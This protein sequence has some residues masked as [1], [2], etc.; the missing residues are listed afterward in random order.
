MNIFKD[1]TEGLEESFSSV[2]IG[3]AG[4][5]GIGSNAAM[6]L[7]RAGVRSIV[8]VDFDKVEIQNLNRQFF[9]A[10]QVGLLKVEAL[11]R[12][13]Q[14]INKD[15]SIEISSSRL[16]IDNA[17]DAFRDCDILVEAVDDSET[18]SFLIEEWSLAFPDKQIIACSG[19]AGISP[20]A[21]VRTQRSGKLSVVGDFHS[22]LESG[23][24]SARVMAVAAAMVAEIQSNLSGGKCVSC[25]G[26]TPG[27]VSLEC[28]GRKIPL[29]GFPCKMVEKTI[30]GMVSS[31]KGADAT[32]TIKIEI[33]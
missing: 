5:G 28:N 21:E 2:K 30:R 9:F 7:V 10:D 20:L 33:N 1:C 27:G 12:N 32:G 23:T 18:K 14:R 4:A 25:S 17:C 29:I 3:I 8:L 15:L 26:C 31:L 19:I 13:L 22:T 24:F 11:S 16:T 6:L